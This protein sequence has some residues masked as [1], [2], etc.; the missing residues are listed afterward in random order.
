MSKPLT[1]AEARAAAD[2]F[3]AEADRVERAAALEAAGLRFA[4]AEIRAQVAK[5]LTIARDRAIVRHK[6]QAA[7]SRTLRAVGRPIELD[8]AFPKALK[9][10]NVTMVEYARKLGKNRSTVKSWVDRPIPRAM[11]EFI[12]ADLGVPAT[13]VSWPAGIK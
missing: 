9:R 8:H 2:Q 1:P 7:D 3:D 11:A 12:E 5:G 4:A 10:A 6:M 13:L